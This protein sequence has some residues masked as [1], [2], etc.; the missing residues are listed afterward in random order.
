MFCSTCGNEIKT[1]LS[2]CNRCGAR[3]DKI[4]KSGGDNSSAA[5]LSMA[6]GFVCL[7]GLGLTVGLIGMLLRNSVNSEVIVMLSLAFL[8]TIFATS[9]LM[10]QQISRRSIKFRSR[11]IKFA[12]R[13]PPTIYRVFHLNRQRLNFI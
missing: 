7:G 5:Y 12:Q 11:K 1:G 4:E 2:Y 10:I 3:V 8:A 13:L 6:T 9:F